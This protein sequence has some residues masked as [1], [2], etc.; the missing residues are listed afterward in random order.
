MAIDTKD[1]RFSFFS[2]GRPHVPTL[3]TP[4]GTFG[5]AADRFQIA[6]MY[7]LD[8]EGDYVLVVGSIR[9][10]VS[11]SGGIRRTA[12]LEGSI[13]RTITLPAER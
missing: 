3:P 6:Y 2:L 9:R 4:D 5:S 8:Q 13:R 11:L 10:T 1:K 7:L 12:S